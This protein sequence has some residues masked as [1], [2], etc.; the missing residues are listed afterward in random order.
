[1]RKSLRNNHWALALTY[2]HNMPLMISSHITVETLIVVLA[3]RGEMSTEKIGSAF[4][5]DFLHVLNSGTRSQANT[6][7]EKFNNLWDHQIE[8]ALTTVPTL[9]SSAAS[10]SISCSYAT[11]WVPEQGVRQMQTIRKKNMVNHN[12]KGDHH[13]VHF[14]VQHRSRAQSRV[15]LLCDILNTGTSSQANADNFQKKNRDDQN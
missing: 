9:V 8:W 3:H 15:L 5:C 10:R 11:F 14:H 12:E 6:G 7:K 1:M 13:R 2:T 4:L